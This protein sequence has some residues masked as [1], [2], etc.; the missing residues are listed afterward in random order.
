MVGRWPL[1]LHDAVQNRRFVKAEKRFLIVRHPGKYPH[2]YNVL[3]HWL[4]EQYP[5][6][7]AFFDLRSLPCRIPDWSRYVLHVPWLQDPV[8]RWSLSG[9]RQANRLAAQCDQRQIPIIN[10]VDRLLNTAKSTG[11]R[12]IGSTGI[13][14]PKM[15]RIE[16]AR[17]FRET[18]GGLELP[19]LVREDWGHGGLVCRADTLAEVRKLPLRRFSRPVAIEFIDVQSHHDR[20][21]RKYRYLAAGDLGMALSLHV[22]KDWKSKGG[23]AEFSEPFRDEELAYTNDPDPNHEQLQ[24]A[25]KALELDFVA[26]D[27][28][29]DHQGKIVVWEANPYPYIHFPARRLYRRQLTA[30][31]LAAMVNLYFQRAGLA[32]P[33]GIAHLLA[34]PSNSHRFD[35]GP[36]STPPSHCAM[37]E[38]FAPAAGKTS[39]PSGE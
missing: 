13:R 8:Q 31:T 12:L 9:Y 30:R 33:L 16:D 19:I 25:R 5:D 6:V 38:S 10:R 11:A 26:F 14:T 7:R 36:N 23:Q 20:R 32:T 22:C 34:L 24:A 39:A 35:A 28:S 37:A 3:L 15:V 27:Y 4:E 1:K 29:Y 17:Q 21:Y 2:F 18:H